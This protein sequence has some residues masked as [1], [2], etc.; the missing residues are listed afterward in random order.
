MDLIFLACIAVFLIAYLYEKHKDLRAYS[1]WCEDLQQRE[2]TALWQAMESASPAGAS[3]HLNRA[4][5]ADLQPHAQADLFGSGQAEQG[6]AGGCVAVASGSQSRRIYGGS[7][8]G[9]CAARWAKD[10]SVCRESGCAACAN[11]GI[12]ND[13]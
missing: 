7:T 8:I 9:L 11:G 5:P 3:V 4:D 6:A 12:A 2:A 13:H 10:A 1:R